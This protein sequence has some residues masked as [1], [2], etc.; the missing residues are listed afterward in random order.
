MDTDSQEPLASDSTQASETGNSSWLER[1]SEHGSE[2]PDT[3]RQPATFRL[4][5]SLGRRGFAPFAI[6]IALGLA[7]LSGLIALELFSGRPAALLRG[8][9]PEDIGCHWLIGDYRISLVGALLLAYISA[10]RVYVAEQSVRNGRLAVRSQPFVDADRLASQRWWGVL[11]G[12]FGVLVT[13]A[14]A[15][16]IAERPVEWTSE[17]WIVPHA[18]NW[19]WCIPFGWIGGRFLYSV[20]TN[21]LLISKHVGELSMGSVFDVGVVEPA[22]AQSR[23]SA[24]VLIVFLGGVSIHFVDP[25]AGVVAF[26]AML[27]LFSLAIAVSFVAMSGA[28]RLFLD[29]KE[30]ELREVR[31][32]LSVV[33]NDL[34]KPGRGDSGRAQDLL[35]IE[36]RVAAASLNLFHV[37]SISRYALYAVL[38]LLSWLGAAAV[39]MI[40]DSLLS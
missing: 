6:S 4:Y 37:S 40:L 24:L 17:Y 23:A 3:W 9:L 7:L 33:A 18:F 10:A 12:L 2:Q 31:A 1:G 20:T 30:R 22:L 15:I 36:A 28:R 27:V 25:G 5:S 35:A 19:L 14:V 39:E 8:A 38:G 13:F 21:A 11:P 16:D 29:T 26:A 32:Q 34:S